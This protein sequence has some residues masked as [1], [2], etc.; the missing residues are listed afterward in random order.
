MWN[1]AIYWKYEH[2]LTYVCMYV[3]MY[4]IAFGVPNRLHLL[5]LHHARLQED[6]DQGVTS[7]TTEAGF[8][9]TPVTSAVPV[10]GFN[11]WAEPDKHTT[12][13][14]ST[15][16]TQVHLFCWL[17]AMCLIFNC[18]WLVIKCDLLSSTFFAN[19]TFTYVRTYMCNCTQLPTYWY[20]QYWPHSRGSLGPTNGLQTGWLLASH[21]NNVQHLPM[22]S[23][24]VRMYAVLSL[25]CTQTHL[26]AAA[27]P[28]RHFISTLLGSST[29]H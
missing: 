5:P 16:W 6:D 18:H 26:P 7:G 29:T 25:L 22:Y 3:C 11:F 19:C 21:S 28:L 9:F 27:L 1:F 23:Y 12:K 10:G 4:V 20:L 14:N 13:G 8:Q 2:I 17:I 15:N 24:I